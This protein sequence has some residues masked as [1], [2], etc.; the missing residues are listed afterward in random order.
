MELRRRLGPESRC[1]YEKRGHIEERPQEGRDRDW[2]PAKAVQGLWQH[3]EQEEA[4]EGS[5]PRACRGSV[6]PPTP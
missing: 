4:Q 2:L 3:R 1:P 6:A 5:S